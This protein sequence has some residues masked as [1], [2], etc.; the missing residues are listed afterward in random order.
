[1][2]QTTRQCTPSFTPYPLHDAD[3][4]ALVSSILPPTSFAT[5]VP[6]DTFRVYDISIPESSAAA[7]VYLHQAEGPFATWHPTCE[8]HAQR[9]TITPSVS[10]ARHVGILAIYITIFIFACHPR[11]ARSLRFPPLTPRLSSLLPCAI[12]VGL[13]DFSFVLLAHT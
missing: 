10:G 3:G 5:F 6:I 12:L 13:V 4:S 11:S 1:M 2:L 7:F 9:H 8:E